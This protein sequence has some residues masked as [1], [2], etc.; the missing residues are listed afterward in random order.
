[1]VRPPKLAILVS[2][3]KVLFAALHSVLL[4]GML[5]VVPLP[6]VNRVMQFFKALI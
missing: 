3:D 6:K 5:G 4:L 2:K 1:M